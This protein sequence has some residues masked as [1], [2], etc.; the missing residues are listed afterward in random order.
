MVEIRSDFFGVD[1]I[2]DSLGRRPGIYT[3]LG[4][5]PNNW[6]R[7]TV[8]FNLCQLPASRAFMT[9]TFDAKSIMK[10]YFE[11]WMFAARE[12]SPCFNAGEN[13]ILS[14]LDKERAKKLYPSTSQ[15]ITDV[16]KERIE[17]IKTIQ[18]VRSLAPSVKMHLQRGLSE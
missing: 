3:L 5:P 18:A 16:N 4:G 1:L 6:S 10:Y 17:A 12:K 15:D 13:T 9:S 2:S 11:A 8:D 14:G 7:S